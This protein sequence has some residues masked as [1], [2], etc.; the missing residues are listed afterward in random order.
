MAGNVGIIKALEAAGLSLYGPDC[1]FKGHIALSQRHQNSVSSNVLG[2]C[3]YWGNHEAL[4]Y[5][6]KK[7]SIRL[8]NFIDVPAFEEV[9]SMTNE[10]GIFTPEM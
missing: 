7:S 9:D 5:C 4:E 6:L 3:A 2:A 1:N 10:Y 8:E